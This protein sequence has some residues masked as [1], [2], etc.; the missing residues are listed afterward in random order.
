MTSRISALVFGLSLAFALAPTMLQAA[1]STMAEA[2]PGKALQ[3]IDTVL[4]KG[5]EAKPG[6]AI[7]M[8][9]TGW[10]FAPKNPKQH[11][12]QIDSSPKGKP[13]AF[14]L[15]A[16]SIIKGWNEGVPGMRVG[17]KRTLIVPAD[18]AFGK[19]GL[20]HVPPNANLIFDIEL[21]DV[22]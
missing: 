10:M 8:H 22:K 1:P 5:P 7:T 20:G 12:M 6:S 15:G 16:E 2:K 9:Y 14:Q 13:F 11:G 3:K 18:M 17:G 19:A 21:V 4:G